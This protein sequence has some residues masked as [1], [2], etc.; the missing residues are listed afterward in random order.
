MTQR[1]RPKNRKARAAIDKVP[2]YPNLARRCVALDSTICPLCRME[3][4][5]VS[6]RSEPVHSDI[7]YGKIHRESGEIVENNSLHGLRINAITVT[8]FA[9]YGRRREG[10]W[11]EVEEGIR[12]EI[13]RRR[14]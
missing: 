8:R 1:T 11:R 13:G 6:H 3:E 9:C 2:T 7:P 5:S 12:K 14:N 4:E 10:G